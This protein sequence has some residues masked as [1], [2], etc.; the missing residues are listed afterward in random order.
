MSLGLST[1]S[2]GSSLI[3]I[4]FIF[5]CKISEIMEAISNFVTLSYGLQKWYVPILGVLIKS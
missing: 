4:T 3:G 1:P 5:L 2:L